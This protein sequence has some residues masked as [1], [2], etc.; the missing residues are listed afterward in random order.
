MRESEFQ[1]SVKD[2][3]RLLFPGCIVT[4]LDSGDIQGIPDLQ[5][6]YG[7]DWATLETKKNK[8][9]SKQAN[10]EY[11]VNRMN[12]M[13]FSRFIYPENVNHVLRELGDYFQEQERKRSK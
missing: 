7:C 12:D 11:Y 9:A 2:R 6:L 5:I 10:Q 3:L 1:R 8:D 4:K 13:A